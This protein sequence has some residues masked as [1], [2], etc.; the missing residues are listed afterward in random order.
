MF[1]NDRFVALIRHVFLTATENTKR[2]RGQILKL[3]SIE[4]L[5]YG[6]H[7]YGEDSD[8]T[9]AKQTLLEKHF[10]LSYVKKFYDADFIL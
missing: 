10:M 5:R 8:L 6:L 4:M 3:F 7:S 9:E 2:N 1:K